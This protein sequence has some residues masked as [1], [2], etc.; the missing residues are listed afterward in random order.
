MATYLQILKETFADSKRSIN[1][2][3]DLR[4]IVGTKI[5]NADTIFCKA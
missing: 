4:L 5:C 1:L 2:D 3:L